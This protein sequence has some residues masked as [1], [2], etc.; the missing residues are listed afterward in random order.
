MSSAVSP[1]EWGFYI[2]D[3]LAFCERVHQFTDGLDQTQFEN[4]ALRFDATIRNIELIGEAATHIPEI[5]RAQ[6][7]EIPWRMLVATR[8]QLI[9]GYL[10]IDKDIIWSIVTSDV[11]ALRESLKTVKINFTT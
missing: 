4:D 7:R 6:H 9:H 5:V 10:G 3:M 2:A 1:R 8:N 11:P